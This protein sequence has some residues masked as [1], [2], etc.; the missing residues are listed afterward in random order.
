MRQIG[1][2]P[3][4]AYPLFREP[5]TIPAGLLETE[6]ASL[7]DPRQFNQTV[8]SNGYRGQMADDAWRLGE[9]EGE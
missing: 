2:M 8:T 1:E 4:T 9:G 5:T 7:G 3:T 6:T